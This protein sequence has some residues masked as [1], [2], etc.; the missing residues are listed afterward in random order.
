MSDCDII[1]SV[2]GSAWVV[3]NFYW[4]DSP[5][6]LI[7]MSP[8]RALHGILRP[9]IRIPSKPF[10]AK[11]RITFEIPSRSHVKIDIL[12]VR[13][14]SVQTA[15]NKLLDAGKHKIV[16]DAD[17]LTSGVYFIHMKTER[18]SN[19]KKMILMK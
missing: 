10:N 5:R 4:M 6:H 13:G 3:I 11:T 7:H 15:M 1:G 17:M 2:D 8:I 14:R 16:F 9:G 18:F 12:D 19:V